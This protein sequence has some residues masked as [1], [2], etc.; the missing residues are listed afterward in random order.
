[1]RGG[2]RTRVIP[3]RAPCGLAVHGPCPC[4][5]A[6]SKPECGLATQTHFIVQRRELPLTPANRRRAACKSIDR[7]GPG[8]GAFDSPRLVGSCSA[9]TFLDNQLSAVQPPYRLTAKTVRLGCMHGLGHSNRRSFDRRALLGRAGRTSSLRLFIAGAS[10][11]ANPCFLA[12]P[13][14]A[15]KSPTSVRA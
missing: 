5:A 14:I 11:R 10:G 6:F 15:S 2:P 13:A 3:V 8:G 7:W 9:L 12:A 1:M 4:G